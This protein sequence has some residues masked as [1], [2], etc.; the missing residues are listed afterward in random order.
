MTKEIELDG[1]ESPMPFAPDDGWLEALQLQLTDELTD[2]VR[3]FAR[4]RALGVANTGR[5][6]DEYYV[7]ELVQDAIADTFEGVLRWDPKRVSL[8]AHLLR[9]VQFRTRNDRDHAIAFPHDAIG[10]E[11]DRS[12]FAESEASETVQ[13]ERVSET[14]RHCVEVMA[15]L[16]DASTRDK[17]VLRILDAYDAGATTKAEVMAHSKMKSRT[18]HNARIRMGRIVRAFTN[19]KLAGQARA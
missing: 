10:D 19:H 2:R 15:Q 8:E 16:R 12:K 4:L 11:T 17:D 6:V 7:R 14:R 13:T 9:A 1:A 5:K 3:N 18:Y